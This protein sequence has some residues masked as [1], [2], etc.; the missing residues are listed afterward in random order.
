MKLTEVTLQE[1]NPNLTWKFRLELSQQKI[2]V[3]SFIGK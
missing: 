3:I 1:Y 2:L